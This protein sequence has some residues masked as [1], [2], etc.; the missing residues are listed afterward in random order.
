MQKV[1]WEFAPIWVGDNRSSVRRMFY[2]G[3]EIGVEVAQSEI[4]VGP[5]GG[6]FAPHFKRDDIWFDA[7][8]R[9][10]ADFM[11]LALAVDAVRRMGYD[12]ALSLRLPYFPYARQD[13]VDDGGALSAAVMAGLINGLGFRRVMIFD[14]HSDVTPALINGCINIPQALFV[15]KIQKHLEI[16]VVVSPD[17]GAEKKAVKVAAMLERPLVRAFKKRDPASGVIHEFGVVDPALLPYKRCLIVDDI[18]DGGATFIGLARNLRLAG[19][20]RVE[21]YV[22]HGIFS[23]GLDA[24]KG[25]IDRVYFTNSLNT[26]P[27][28]DLSDVI[29]RVV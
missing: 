1:G 23:K 22:T 27:T 26:D 13:R 3:G 20:A 24:F 7:V 12:D 28:R 4:S 29:T 16:D 21:L 17:A 6:L 8:I 19:A 25:L 11:T 9:N 10:S 15:Q 18:C 2:P 5:E 14:A